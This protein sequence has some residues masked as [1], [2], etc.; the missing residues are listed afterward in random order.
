MDILILI[1][2]SVILYFAGGSVYGFIIL[3]GLLVLY[4]LS[5]IKGDT[6]PF[7]KPAIK[8]EIPQKSD[9]KFLKLSDL[10]DMIPQLIG[11]IILLS[12]AVIIGE[13]F[14]YIRDSSSFGYILGFAIIAVIFII[15]YFL[16]H[17]SD[18]K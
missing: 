6:H 12:I 13:F 8:K 10:K 4:I 1:A 17:K 15:L 9:R 2:L 7:K 5:V 16:D 14:K 3:G 11:I 18:K